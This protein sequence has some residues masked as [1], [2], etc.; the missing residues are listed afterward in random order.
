M[1]KHYPA[2]KTMAL[3]AAAV[4]ALTALS[5][6]AMASYDPENPIPST[7]GPTVLV[8]PII[9]GFTDAVAPDGAYQGEL[10][11]RAPMLIVNGEA[12]TDVQAYQLDDGTWMVPLRAVAE[13]AGF[14][15]TFR[16]DIGGAD[17]ALDNLFTTI[18][19]GNNSY[20]FNRVAP[21]ELESEP[22][23]FDGVTFVP[24]SFFD[25][26]MKLSIDANETE[27][28]IG[29][30]NRPVSI[31]ATAG[32]SF[33]IELEENAS[34]G[35]TWSYSIEPEDGLTVLANELIAIDTD[36]IGAPDIRSFTLRADEEGVYTITFTY[37]RP[38]EAAEVEAD[39]AADADDVAEV[40]D[41]V[42]A[43]TA[44]TVVYT[45]TVTNAA[46]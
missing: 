11:S 28:T 15:V 38:F 8:A 13:A 29:W 32:G 14:S 2:T 26:V 46:E 43:E 34:T 12:A 1:K 31:E 6:P 7:D 25:R 9:P 5:A 16:P 40:E 22:V 19:F 24:L 39:D 30:D 33:V 23:V 42:D 44:K 21:F 17:I 27:I 3:A 35:Y 10:P 20:F 18:Y 37:A 45:I 4:F 36:V 41:T